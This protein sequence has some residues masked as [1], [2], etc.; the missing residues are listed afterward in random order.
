MG[1][2]TSI[3]MIRKKEKDPLESE[4]RTQERVSKRQIFRESSART[5]PSV[6]HGR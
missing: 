6:R 3:P 4:V 1:H 5:V 2:P